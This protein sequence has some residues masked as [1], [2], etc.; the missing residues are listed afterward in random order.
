[1]VAIGQGIIK[2]EALYKGTNKDYLQETKPSTNVLPT[3]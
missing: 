3:T 1:M 2:R